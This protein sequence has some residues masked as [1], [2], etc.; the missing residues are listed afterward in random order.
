MLEARSSC[1]EVVLRKVEVTEV[2]FGGRLETDHRL[3]E[4][5]IVQVSV[6]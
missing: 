2:K 3:S 6:D 1:Q 5:D 4:H